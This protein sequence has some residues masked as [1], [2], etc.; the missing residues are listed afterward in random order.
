M[1]IEKWIRGEMNQFLESNENG[2]MAYRAH[3]MQQRQC[4][5]GKSLPWVS[6]LKKQRWQ[7]DRGMKH[8]RIIA[9]MSSVAARPA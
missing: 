2:G 4:Q 7:V 8:L 9:V 1:E 3:G 6:I 5:E